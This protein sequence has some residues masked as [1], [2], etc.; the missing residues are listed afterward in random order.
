MDQGKLDE[1]CRKFDEADR[2]SGSW[3]TGALAKLAECHEKAGRL[4]SAWGTW[5]K[6]E[7]AASRAG[8]KERADYAKARVADLDGRAP[9]LTIVVPDALRDEAGLE[10]ERDD[11]P[12]V[13][14][15]WGLPVRVDP[16]RRVLRVRMPRHVPWEATVDLRAGDV[17][18]VLPAVLAEIPA[19]TAVAPAPPFPPDETRGRAQRRAGIGIG[20]A[21]VGA[22]V[23]GGALGVVALTRGHDASVACGPKLCASGA[24][25]AML[26]DGARGFQSAAIVSALLGAA[27]LATGIALYVTAP[28][29]PKPA[30]R[31]VLRGL[32]AFVQVGGAGLRGRW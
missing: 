5:V 25:G 32:E 6:V 29:A 3:A 13:R 22:L 31:G 16:G 9:K 17:Q 23:A 10:I 27:G 30:P 24:P 7:L 19:P 26:A 8:Q 20:A 28:S 21:G 2:T 14:A 11:A 18:I 15:E 12:L 1:A 4:A